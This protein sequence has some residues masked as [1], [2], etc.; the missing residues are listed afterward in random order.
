MF[1]SMD[2][3]CGEIILSSSTSGI[4]RSSEV[5][6]SAIYAFVLESR[7]W[8]HVGNSNGLYDTGLNKMHSERANHSTGCEPTRECCK[9]FTPIYYC[10]NFNCIGRQ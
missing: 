4:L 6:S 2:K 5:C 1:F 8:Q 9:A 7:L 10:L 3:I